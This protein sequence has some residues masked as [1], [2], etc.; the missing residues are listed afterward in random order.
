MRV[1][2]VGPPGSGKGTQGPPLASHLGVPYLSTGEILRTEAEEGT[3]L[4][5][6]VAAV[7]HSG[8]LVP[9][10]LV[11]DVVAAALDGA[12]DG[13]VL[14]GFPRTVTQAEMIERP[15]G[16]VA[17][18]DVVVHLAIPTS[19]VHERLALRAAQDDRPD[20]HDPAVADRRVRVYEDRTAPLI[21]RYRDQ[22]RLV[23]VDADRPVEEVTAAVISAVDARR[24]P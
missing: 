24:A 3:A 19:V 11:L 6:R 21:D 5:R 4:G 20:D 16:P 17:P 18:P 23:T 10:D 9:D 1:V 22:G 8:G 2:L 15:E 12:G 13:Y 7:L 14:D